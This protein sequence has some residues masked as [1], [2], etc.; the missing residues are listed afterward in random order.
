MHSDSFNDAGFTLRQ[1]LRTDPKT[2]DDDCKNSSNK[3]L[4]VLDTETRFMETIDYLR[5]ELDDRY[6]SLYFNSHRSPILKYLC[7]NG[8]PFVPVRYN[9]KKHKRQHTG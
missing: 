7:T 2:A 4:A 6:S 3:I 9:S 1:G 5:Q 8:L